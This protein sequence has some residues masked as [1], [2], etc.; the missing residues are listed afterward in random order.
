[1][2]ELWSSVTECQRL[3][4]K[5]LSR[6]LPQGHTS[7][8]KPRHSHLSSS[9]AKRRVHDTLTATIVRGCPAAASSRASEGASLS[10]NI[11][12][13][14]V[15]RLSHEA[16]RALTRSTQMMSLDSQDSTL[17][18]LALLRSW[19]QELVS[20]AKADEGL[21]KAPATPAHHPV[22]SGFADLLVQRH[23]ARERLP[24]TSS[25]LVHFGRRRVTNRV[26]DGS[27]CCLEGD[28][29]RRRFSLPKPADLFL[30][31]LSP[32]R[33]S[34][35]DSLSQHRQATT[36]FLLHAGRIG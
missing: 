13:S 35:A 34:V 19:K 32:C 36:D 8:H 27:S 4:L 9:G 1:M 28:R 29:S 3:N 11:L 31:A 26:G 7:F 6:L 12:L 20:S 22:P 30:L 10:I 25:A 21:D 23:R 24:L 2:A 16:G 18:G 5:R 15:W 17:R 14:Q 33:R